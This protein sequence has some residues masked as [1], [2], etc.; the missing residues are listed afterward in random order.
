MPWVK[1]PMPDPIIGLSYTAHDPDSCSRS[2]TASELQ[3]KND[4]L[5]NSKISDCSTH[6]R[7]GY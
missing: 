3:E 7:Q 2:Y 1:G 5:K 4:A 6:F